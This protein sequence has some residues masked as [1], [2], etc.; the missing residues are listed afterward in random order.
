[1]GTDRR[2]MFETVP[3]T[4]S[5]KPDILDTRVAINYKVSVRTVLVLAHPSF[6]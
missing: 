5:H 6:G 1:M 2:P 4:A 3:G